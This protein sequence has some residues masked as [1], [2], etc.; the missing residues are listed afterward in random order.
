MVLL[1]W[2]L[3]NLEL[4]L[5][6]V[7]VCSPFSPVFIHSECQQFTLKQHWGLGVSVYM[8]AHTWLHAG[9]SHVLPYQEQPGAQWGSS[10][11]A[12]PDSPVLQS[13]KHIRACLSL[14]RAGPSLTRRAS[15]LR[16]S[17]LKA[18]K[19]V[20][21]KC[22]ALSKTRR[23]SKM[24]PIICGVEEPIPEAAISEGTC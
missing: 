22:N 19:E 17:F 2:G 10:C 8:C 6:R 12:L 7:S 20:W 13:G 18:R 21:S 14:P 4:T 11:P 9:M 3:W 5:S 16:S 23:G 24:K 1:V 15:D